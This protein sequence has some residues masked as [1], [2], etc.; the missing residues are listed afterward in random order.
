MHTIKQT[1]EVDISKIDWK[2]H[3]RYEIES[4]LSSTKRGMDYEDMIEY[5]IDLEKAILKEDLSFFD[6]W[7]VCY[8]FLYF[9]QNHFTWPTDLIGDLSTRYFKSN[10]ELALKYKDKIYKTFI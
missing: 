9:N 7:E 4:W 5:S 2:T 1:I 6:E 8:M 10:L 3:F